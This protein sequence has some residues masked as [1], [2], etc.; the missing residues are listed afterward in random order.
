MSVYIDHNLDITGPG[1]LRPIATAPGV[2]MFRVWS[3][4]LSEFGGG[5]LSR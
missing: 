1:P 3:L 2:G 5:A 4:Q